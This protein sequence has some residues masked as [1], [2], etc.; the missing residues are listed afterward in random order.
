[1]CVVCDVNLGRR[2]FLGLAGAGLAASLLPSGVFAAGGPTTSLTADQALA[3]LKEGNAKYVSSPQ[4]CE[5]DLAKS[6]EHVAKGQAPW[7][8]IVSCA[9]SRVPPELLFGGQGVGELFIARNAG[10]MVDTPTM[11]TMPAALE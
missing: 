9:D 3:K 11:G 10:N 4:L 2:G 5:V 6:R 1:M 8:T 7:A